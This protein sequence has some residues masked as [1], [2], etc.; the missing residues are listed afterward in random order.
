MITVPIA[1]NTELTEDAAYL[2]SV[3]KAKP[4]WQNLG[5]LTAGY[6]GRITGG[7]WRSSVDKL[8]KRGKAKVRTH[9]GRVQLMPV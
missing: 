9:G 7:D 1:E 3:L 8:V 5:P 6:R 4:G 2:Y